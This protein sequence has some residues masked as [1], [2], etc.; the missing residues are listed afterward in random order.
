MSFARRRRIMLE[1]RTP[2]IGL[3]EVQAIL[4]VLAKILARGLATEQREHVL[5]GMPVAIDGKKAPDEFSFYRALFDTYE[6]NKN[7]D[8]V[9]DLTRRI[10]GTRSFYQD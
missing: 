5:R 6:S 7:L 10:E 8:Y 9:L 1:R 3:E 2:S 4:S